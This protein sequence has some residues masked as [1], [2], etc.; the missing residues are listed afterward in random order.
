M[1]YFR[2]IYC[3]CC[4]EPSNCK[5]CFWLFSFTCLIM[6]SVNKILCVHLWIYC[7]YISMTSGTT[8][9][10]SFLYVPNVVCVLCAYF[11]LCVSFF[12]LTYTPVK[13]HKCEQP[14]TVKLYDALVESLT[15]TLYQTCTM[16]TDTHTHTLARTS[17]RTSTSFFYDVLTIRQTAS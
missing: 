5:Y 6:L 7:V 15:E 8:S 11:F 17:T 4:T 9:F 1:D 16:Y 13:Q 3:V 14:F 2:T 10:C 12:R